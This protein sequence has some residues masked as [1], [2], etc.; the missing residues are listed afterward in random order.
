L[1]DDG[2]TTS[3]VTTVHRPGQEDE[4]YHKETLK[5][6][7]WVVQK[8]SRLE[9]IAREQRARAA[10]RSSGGPASG[11]TSSRKSELRRRKRCTTV[12]HSANSVK[13]PEDADGDSDEEPDE[14]GDSGVFEELEK[15]HIVG[16]GMDS[17][18]RS[19]AKRMLTNRNLVALSSES[20]RSAP[21]SRGGSLSTC[22]RREPRGIH[23]VF[24][25]CLVLFR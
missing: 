9:K 13:D 19:A 7:G 2:Y 23:P 17:Q 4:Q 15:Y 3:A 21:P 25:L 16:K 24:P 1:D 20:K 22:L 10:E 5:I 11:L 12:W 8:E 6:F 18:S 14:S